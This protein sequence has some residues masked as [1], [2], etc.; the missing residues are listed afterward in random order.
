MKKEW[1]NPEMDELMI[2]V[3]ADGSSATPDPDGEV[4]RD[5]DGLFKVNVGG[6][7]LSV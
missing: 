5:S 3:T 7:N 6:S 2:N 1:N 4:Y